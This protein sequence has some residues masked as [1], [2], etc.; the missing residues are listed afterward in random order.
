MEN[1]DLKVTAVVSVVLIDQLIRS[2]KRREK[3]FVLSSRTRLERRTIEGDS[4]VRERPQLFP[5]W[6]LSTS[7]HVKSRGNPGRLRS[8]TKYFL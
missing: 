6:F 7:R 8:K 5:N 2:V 1:R 3:R 4:P